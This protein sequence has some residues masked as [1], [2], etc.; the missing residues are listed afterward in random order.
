V[1][2][3]LREAGRRAARLWHRIRAWRRIRFTAGGVAFSVGTFAVGFAALNTGNNLLYLLLGSMLGFIAVSGWLSEQAIR[4]LVVERRVPRAVTVERDLVLTYQVRNEKKRLPS[5]AVEIHERGLPEPAF[6]AHVPAGGRATIR[7]ANA[8]VRRGVYPLGTVTLSTAF[9]FGLFRKERDLELPGEIV[10]WPRHDLPVGEPAQGFGNAPRGAAS[11]RGEAGA[12]GEYRSLRTYRVGDDPRDIH[13][14]S[15]ARLGQPVVR[16]YDRRASETRWICLDTR[17]TE[18]DAAERA[19]EVAASLFARCVAERRPCGLSTPIGDVRP[20]EGVGVLE[21]ALDDLARV[22]FTADAPL[23][24]PP[25]S[26]AACVLVS[27]TGAPGFADTVLVERGE[28]DAEAG[29][30]GE[31]TPGGGPTRDGEAAA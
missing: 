29:P 12:R 18:G 30:D 6:L 27:L 21:R 28:G 26:R 9:P 15:T 4:G 20:G 24:D 1:P 14:R 7:S 11:A 5:L 16:E 23:P 8:F 2:S 22:D 31:S 3:R 13:W 25:V 17:G 10:V 19:V